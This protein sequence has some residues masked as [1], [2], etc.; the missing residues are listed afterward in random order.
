[1]PVPA[2]ETV[3]GVAAAAHSRRISAASAGDAGQATSAAQ[4]PPMRLSSTRYF[5]IS[6]GSRLRF[7]RG[8]G[9]SIPRAGRSARGQSSVSCDGLSPTRMIAW[10]MAR[11]SDS[12]MSV[13]GPW[14]SSRRAKLDALW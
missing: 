6:A 9:Y 8:T 10:S 2:P 7:M 11:E 12:R 3:T 13:G 5:A 14:S 4:P 1:M